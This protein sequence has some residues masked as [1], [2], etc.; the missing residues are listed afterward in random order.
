MENSVEMKII[1][2]VLDAIADQKL[3]AGTKLGESDLSAIF[4]CNRA[5]IRRALAMLT[6]YGVVN[7]IANKGA[8]VATPSERE[9]RQVF[10]ARRA[11]EASICKNVVRNAKTED[12]ARLRAH[13][14]EEN[15]V[16]G[17]SAPAQASRAEALRLSRRFHLILADLGNNEVLAQFLEEL[18]LRSSL[19]LGC[20]G[21]HRATLC[22][23]GEHEK[24]VE[25]IE[26]R[27]EDLAIQLL[28][29]HLLHLENEVNF[30]ARRSLSSPLGNIL[31]APN[32]DHS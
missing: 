4:S 7:L 21:S 16:L 8:F 10:Q 20:Y 23:A 27:R 30:D 14:A 19:I 24:I 18:T 2:H 12:F 13:L 15:A 29:Q 26:A 17:P 9:S 6:G 25:A 11:I 32:E 5:Q 31:G 3:R 22:A 1:Y 28:D